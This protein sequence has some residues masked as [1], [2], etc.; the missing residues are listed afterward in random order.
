MG[1]VE[2]RHEHEHGHEHGH[3]HEHDDS[4]PWWLAALR[5]LVVAACAVAVWFEFPD[6]DPP[7]LVIADILFLP[8]SAW[9]YFGLIF[10]GW[11][12][13]KGAVEDIL[14]RRMTMELSMSLAIWA[15]TYTGYFFPAL[16]I[17]FFVLVAEILEGMTVERGR[18]AI[19]D[20]IELLPHAVSVRRGN[21]VQDVKAKD[22]AVGDIILVA[23]GALI[24]VDGTVISGHSFVDEARISGESAPAEKL[25]GS[26]A[27]AGTVNHTG[28]LEIRAERIGPDTSYG[29][30]IEAVEQAER[31]R[32]PVQRLADKLAA[33][34]IY[35]AIAFALLEYYYARSVID[36]ISVIIVAGACGVAAGT[37][38]AILGGIGRSARLG[39]I[40][41]GGVHLEMLGQ[42]KTIVL[43]KTGTLT[44]GYAEVRSVNP[45]PGVSENELMAAAVTAELRSEHP[46][47]KAIVRHAGPL[48]QE[49]LATDRFSYTPGRGLLAIAG[50]SSILVG[51][52]AWMEENAIVISA[53]PT[54]GA[55][56]DV[57][58][59]FVAR[60]GRFLGVI[61]LA[62]E[63][64]QEARSAIDR[65]KK[66]DLR[67]VLLSGD[68]TEVVRAVAQRSNIDEYEACLLPE[69]KASRVRQ[70]V[71]QDQIVA[72]V[73]DGINDAPALA[74]AAVGIAMGSGTDVARESADIVLLGNDLSRLVD[75]IEVARRTRRIILFNF[76]GTIAVDIVGVAL[77][78][79]GYVGPLLAAVIHTGSELAFILNSARLLPGRSLFNLRSISRPHPPEPGRASN[80]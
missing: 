42:V 50:G 29:K 27:R 62:D 47:A 65:L 77:I 8:F 18:R 24:P 68:S 80:P 25:A 35:M 54:E 6:V 53:L 66:M 12:I 70:L 13:F 58:R 67:V 64:R 40:I 20:L 38:L 2:D 55:G 48:A 71:S 9:A 52:N 26:P 74:A 73:G 3:G 17:T 56:H 10:G 30:I 60:D 61:D 4:G 49:A 7:V 79:M 34:I 69:E 19:K 76:A 28:T 31:S 41:K 22:L 39:A 36:A 32:A 14:D 43:D 72:M 15:A 21:L 75:T 78:F 5:L 57:S 11:P 1:H 63:I 37:P 59:I 33:Y 44:C 16:F 46:F 23:P 51:S 45:A